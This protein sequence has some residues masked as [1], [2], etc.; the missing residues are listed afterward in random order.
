MC[1]KLAK[2]KILILSHEFPPFGGGG[3]RILAALCAELHKRGFE[4]TVLTAAP[5]RA[6]RQAFPFK[7][8]YFP[9]FR[10]A[11][12]KTSVPAM[13]L[14]IAQALFYCIGGKARGHDLLFSNM[15]IP[16]GIAGIAARRFLRLPHLI[17]YHNTEVSQ[18]RPYRAGPVFRWA[19]L[20]IGRRASVNMFIS[21]GLM[22]MALSYGTL[23]CPLVL[24]NASQIRSASP[25]PYEKGDKIFLFAARMEPVK[26]P[27][28]L[29][30]AIRM[31]SAGPDNSALQ[32]VRF[33]L[34]GSGSMYKKVEQGIA[35]SGLGALVTQE[36]AA[37]FERMAG[38]YR[39]I[40]A[41]VLPSI[42]EGYPTTVL[43]AGAFG[44]PAI[45]TEAVGNRD[46]IVHDDTGLLFPLYDA[47][48]FAEAIRRIALD[49]GL[50][51]RL[52]AGA[53]ERSQRFTIQN[54]A[55]I[56]VGALNNLLR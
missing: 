27:L 25:L 47:A 46:A 33:L 21:K 19:C 11:R 14:F 9:T 8:V 52:G 34:V 4:P 49:P 5:P 32:G 40:Y 15:S 24:P 35:R 2:P 43:E 16:A 1:N 48:A 6:L 3:G 56:F 44:V 38:L 26:N 51:N 54:T 31:L 41:L 39:S 20:F 28:L 17:W 30:E 12:F 50:R 10:T 22:D 36:P 7:V 18:N 29:L 55:D 37:P 53:F 45:G 13:A 23:P 42:V